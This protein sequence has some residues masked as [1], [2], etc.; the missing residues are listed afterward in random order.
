METVLYLIGGLVLFVACPIAIGQLI[1][2]IDQ[3]IDDEIQP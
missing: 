1:A 2:G 3:R